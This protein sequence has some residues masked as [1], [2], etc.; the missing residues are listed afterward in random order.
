MSP[1]ANRVAIAVFVFTAGFVGNTQSVSIAGKLTS[2]E[3]AMLKSGKFR[4]K[5]GKGRLYRAP[6]CEFY[7]NIFY[8]IY[9]MPFCIIRLKFFVRNR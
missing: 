3:L 4:K 6:S 9:P 2:D 1:L 5:V 7:M 8:L